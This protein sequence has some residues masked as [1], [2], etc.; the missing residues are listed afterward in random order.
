MKNVTNNLI[1]RRITRSFYSVAI[2]FLALAFT[3]CEK[4]VGEGP[5]V[6]ETRNVTDFKKIAVSISGKVNYKIDPVYKVEVQAQQNI[7][8][9]L[10]T[11]K[12]GDELIIKFQ[13]GK[14]VRSH[15]EIL[16]TISA[17]Y[18]E[19]IRMS[20][21]AAFYLQNTLTASNVDLSVSGSGFINLSNIALS[22]KLTG[23]IS[24]SGNITIVNGMA[25]NQNLT[26]SG[27]GHIDAE[28][29][30]VEKS[31]V[32]ISGSGNMKVNVSQDLD[33]TI[34]GSGSVM[35]RGTPVVT[36]HISGSGKVVHL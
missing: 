17:P 1:D 9:I 33:A 12:I 29:V 10:E 8:N 5:L 23:N 35:Y 7:L 3:S 22:D 16:V 18:A 20:G 36:T 25:K 28:N 14:N 31:V 26:I 11:K 2:A 13:D 34:S 15:E 30:Q 6:T 27:S 4:V 32:R 19:A 21:S 24:G